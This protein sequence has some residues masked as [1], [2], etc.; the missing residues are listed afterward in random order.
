MMIAHMAG[1][2]GIDL[3]NVGL[4]TPLENIET[5]GVRSTFEWLKQSTPGR[6]PTVKDLARMRSK[7]NSHRWDS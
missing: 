6:T 2:M 3:G 4:D 7:T 5:E 1:G